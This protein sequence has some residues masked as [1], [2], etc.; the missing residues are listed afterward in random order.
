MSSSSTSDSPLAARDD[1]CV[2]PL[3]LLLCNSTTRF[4][5]CS[6][7]HGN[8]RTGCGM[9]LKNT[10]ADRR[11]L[12]RGFLGVAVAAPGCSGSCK[13]ASG[14]CQKLCWRSPS[15]SSRSRGSFASNPSTTSWS[16]GEAPVVMPS[17]ESRK[18][19]GKSLSRQVVRF[20][21]VSKSG[22]YLGGAWG[23]S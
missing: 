3:P 1:A 14:V 17:I 13:V 5:T 23:S 6:H 2:L 22:V 18:H 9:G 10:C 21:S 16:S 8:S 20:N 12:A 19:F 15:Q 7:L 11:W 4:V